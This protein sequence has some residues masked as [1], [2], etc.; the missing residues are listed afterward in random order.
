MMPT[1]PNEIGGRTMPTPS[2]RIVQPTQINYAGASDAL[3]MNNRAN[4]EMISG[5]MNVMEE[6]QK[7]IKKDV[8]LVGSYNEV[9]AKKQQLTL[10][11][12]DGQ[13]GG[14]LSRQ[15][16]N[17][18]GAESD[19]EKNFQSI[20][21]KAMSG[22]NDPD[23][24]QQMR[25][26]LD[27][28]Y[29]SGLGSI[30]QH[31]TSQRNSFSLEI[32]STKADLAAQRVGFDPLNEETFQK[33][34]MEVANAALVKAQ[35]SGSNANTEIMNATSGLYRNRI[36]ALINTNDANMVMQAHKI[37]K[38][39]SEKG[40]FTLDDSDAIRNSFKSVLPK[41]QAHAEFTKFM[42]GITL[43][44]VSASELANAVM[45]VESRGRDYN[46]DGSVVT[47]QTGAKGRM[48]VLDSTNLDPGFG[49]A[50]AKDKSLEERA[51]VGRDYIAAMEKRYGDKTLAL[52]AYNW[53]PGNVDDYIKKAGDP[54]QGKID[55]DTFLAGVPS[56]EARSYVPKVMSAL[57]IGSGRVDT[58][59]AQRYADTLDPD[60]GKEFMQL[61]EQ[62][63]KATEARISQFKQTATDDAMS[64]F[65]AA[66]GNKWA[67]MPNELRQ[68]V[69]QAGLKDQ[70]ENY[71]GMTVQSTASYLYS[72]EPK[73]L[74]AIN[75]DDPSIRL[76]L[77]QNDYDKWKM[78]QKSL[79][80]S[81]SLVTEENR[82]KMVK[83]AF[84]R[85]GIDKKKPEDMIRFNELLDARIEAYRDG[86]NGRSPSGADIQTIIDDLFFKRYVSGEV[87]LFNDGIIAPIDVKIDDISQDELDKIKG[88]LIRN[89]VP[90]TDANIINLYTLGNKEK[91]ESN[92]LKGR[93]IY[94]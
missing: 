47:S 54:R 11:Y 85:R 59:Q 50:P 49:V 45:Q 16:K 33:S 90:L 43:E 60:V 38:D 18:I 73:D 75:F 23:V 88:I 6:R 25:A 58:N 62:Q 67:N 39:A 57:G 14:I 32:A 37:Y 22:I 83:N 2:R 44:N 1:L 21:E 80:S 79:D 40:E 30:K 93:M 63:N 35:L 77:S 91:P 76:N 9:E 20:R 69:T 81:A 17:A 28:L 71:T 56:E 72:L 61:S 68:R 5:A 3:A 15:G 92:P 52:L 86:N 24:L 34:I 53:G 19:Y 26:S 82:V 65:A 41:A 94:G 70:I 10:L 36:A 64:F 8:A 78:K 29:L 55:M 84:D 51:R 46:K 13:N 27:S 48:Q 4:Q 74:K 7:Q 87:G 42:G 66:D 31:E 89:G 12:G